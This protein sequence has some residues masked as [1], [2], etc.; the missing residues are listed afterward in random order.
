MYVITGFLKGRTVACI[1]ANKDRIYEMTGTRIAV[2]IPIRPMAS[3]LNAPSTAPSWMAAAVPTPCDEA[4][5][6]NPLAM[7]LSIPNTFITAGPT[8]LPKIPTATTITAVNDGIPPFFSEIPMAIGVVT[9][10]GCRVAISDWSAPISFPMAITLIIP[11]IAPT[12]TEVRIET[13]FPFRYFICSN[14]TYPK[15]TTEGPNMK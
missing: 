10:L 5:K 4:P 14:K 7:R 2:M 11:T 6:A 13:T 1:Q 15:A 12:K 8:I 9:D 3:P